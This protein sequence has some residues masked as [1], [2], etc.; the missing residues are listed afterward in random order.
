MRTRKS[1]TTLTATG[2]IN[3]LLAVHLA[4]MPEA[5]EVSAPRDDEAGAGQSGQGVTAESRRISPFR[6]VPPRVIY[7][8]ACRH[9]KIRP[10]LQK[11]KGGGPPCLTAERMTPCHV[12]TD[13][14][15]P[16]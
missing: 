14:A 2:K 15:V 9:A 1:A 7:R 4:R 16:G 3:D 5:V 13:F 12:T 11:Y 8:R 6:G 10:L